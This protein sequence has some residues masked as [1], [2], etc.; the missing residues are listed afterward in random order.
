MNAV[1]DETV[2]SK[3]THYK[4]DN[5]RKSRNKGREVVMPKREPD[6]IIKI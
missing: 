6:I 3:K 4:N 1:S 5:N 2:A